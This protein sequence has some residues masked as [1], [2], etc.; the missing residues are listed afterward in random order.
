MRVGATG[1]DAAHLLA[2]A[3]AALLGSRD[4]PSRVAANI[5]RTSGWPGRT[6]IIRPIAAQA[7]DRALRY[8]DAVDPDT[9]NDELV[10]RAQGYIVPSDEVLVGWICD[11][12]FATMSDPSSSSRM[13][14]E[15]L[16]S[17]ADWLTEHCPSRGRSGG[18]ALPGAGSNV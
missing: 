1:D 3:R 2:S 15:M 11:L 8:V 14:A 17:V 13:G 5:V 6:D 7:A 9:D 4:G 18:R 16:H 12:S 10:Y